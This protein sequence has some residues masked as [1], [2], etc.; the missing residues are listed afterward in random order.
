M[1]GGPSLPYEEVKTSPMAK[2]RRIQ[3]EYAGDVE[4]NVLVPSAEKR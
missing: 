2:G 3:G 1:G 4:D